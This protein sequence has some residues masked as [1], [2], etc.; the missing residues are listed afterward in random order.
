MRVHVRRGFLRTLACL[1]QRCNV[2]RQVLADT[3]YQLGLERRREHLEHDLGVLPGEARPDTLPLSGLGVK[4]VERPDAAGA[5]PQ[6]SMELV[7]QGGRK[8][9]RVIHGER[10]SQGAECR[11]ER[12]LGLPQRTEPRAI[13]HGQN[14]RSD[15]HDQPR[16]S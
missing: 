11:A 13:P 2:G 8:G 4:L 16:C 10:K 9:A 6:R 3:L 14:E 12:A 1:E 15:F 5:A 7:R